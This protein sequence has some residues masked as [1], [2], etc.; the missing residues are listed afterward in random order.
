MFV[1]KSFIGRQ[2]FEVNSVLFHSSIIE[3]IFK[4]NVNSSCRAT[5]HDACT[6]FFAVVVCYS[7]FTFSFFTMIRI[8]N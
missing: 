3:A 7:K 8:D 5:M 2:E 6:S 4:T 1:S